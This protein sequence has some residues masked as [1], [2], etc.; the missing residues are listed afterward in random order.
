MALGIVGFAGGLQA[1]VSAV[2]PG[3]V[4][5]SISYTQVAAAAG[6]CLFCFFDHF[7]GGSSVTDQ[8]D[9]R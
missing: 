7:F 4:I 1:D 9:R 5:G 3:A 6:D 8:S 2:A